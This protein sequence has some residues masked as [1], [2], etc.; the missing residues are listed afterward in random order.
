MKHPGIV[1]REDFIE[2][3]TNVSTMAQSLMLP[4]SFIEKII[5]GECDIDRLTGA[6][7][8]IY[9][10]TKLEYFNDLQREYDENS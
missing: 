5:L 8:A 3:D 1:L 2:P 7:L 6:R 9:F 10:N 4:L